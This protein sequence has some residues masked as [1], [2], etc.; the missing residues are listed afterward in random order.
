MATKPCQLWCLDRLAYRGVVRRVRY[1][2]RKEK[3]TLLKCSDIGHILDKTMIE[4]LSLT[5]KPEKFFPGDV[6]LRE[7]EENYTIYFIRSGSVEKRR[8][9]SYDRVEELKQ[10][11][12]FGLESLLDGGSNDATYVASAIVSVYF[13]TKNE[14]ESM[15]GNIH[16]VQD[17]KLKSR[18]VL[19]F[20]KKSFMDIETPR[21]VVLEL[22]QLNY[23]NKIG[24]GDFSEVT[25]VQSKISGD[26]YALKAFSKHFIVQKGQQNQLLNEFRILRYLDHPNIG[27]IHC[28]MQDE[29]KVYF[30]LD[31]LPGGELLKYLIK[32]G[33][34]SEDETRF[35]VASVVLALDHTTS[36]MIAHRDIKPEN[37]KCTHAQ[38]YSLRLSHQNSENSYQNYAQ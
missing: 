32:R 4:D 37:C 31:L 21:R 6:I 24:K 22:D 16:D 13:F 38:L 17:G 35:Y 10:N 7:G 9:D 27:K 1:N 36:M 11:D 28:A 19:R 25:L 30:L 29:R 5:L 18:S 15:V 14:F 8:K 33:K 12:S 26:V 3:L 34:F 20:E 23:F 2:N